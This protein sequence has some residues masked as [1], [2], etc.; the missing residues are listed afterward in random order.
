MDMNN[1]LLDQ[2]ISETLERQE[3]ETALTE[4]VM[5]TLRKEQ[6]RAT[7]RRWLRL[8]TFCFGLPLVIVG[9][10]LGIWWFITHVDAA[11]YVM[12]GIAISVAVM[13]AVV[14]KAV[15]IFSPDGV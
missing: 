4:Q 13:I 1:E 11:Q 6:R 3:L 14:S 7:C 10:G 5:L 15:Q 2:L 12:G 8:L 9:Y